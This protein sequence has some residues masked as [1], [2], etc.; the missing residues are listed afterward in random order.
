M[1]W[2]LVTGAATGAL[3]R[4]PVTTSHQ[5]LTIISAS[6]RLSLRVITVW[7]KHRK[8]HKRW[9]DNHCELAPAKMPV[10]VS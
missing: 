9:L 8:A 5:T 2:S 7:G 4:S 1:M 3:A 10:T 6:S